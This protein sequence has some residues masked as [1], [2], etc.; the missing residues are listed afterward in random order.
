MSTPLPAS[1]V[2]IG[3]VLDEGAWSAFQKRVLLLAALAFAVDGLANQVLGLAI[4]ALIEHWGAARE[5]FA[6]VAAVGLIGVAVG[7]VLG[8]IAGDRFGRRSALIGSVLLFG[9]MTLASAFVRDIDDLLLVR[10]IDGIGLGAAIPNGAALI[11]E[12]T[13]LRHRSVAIAVGMVFIPVGGLLSGVLGAFVLPELGWRGLFLIAGLAPTL[14]AIVF[15]FVLPESPRVLVRRPARHRE[16]RALLARCGHQPAPDSTLVDEHAAGSRTPLGALFGPGML[17]NT[18]AL[19]VGFFFCL[20]ASYTMFS[21]VPTVLASR[22]FS[23]AMTSI[24]TTAFHLGGVIGGVTGGWLIARLG[25][26]VAVPG[27][28]AGCVLG[29][30]VLGLLPA[31]AEHGVAPTL[32]ALVVEG[33]F[34]AGLH[35][36]LY[37]LAAVIY[38]S[39][40]RATGIGA[41]SAVGRIG[42]VASSYTG[43]LTLKLGGSSS[44]FIVIAGAAAVSLAG[45]ALIRHHIPGRGSTP[46]APGDARRPASA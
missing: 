3:R 12:F 22:G 30:L 46:P 4:P 26:R 11:S 27:L 40:V 43:V 8:G 1:A 41:A 24:G 37:T 33:F 19:W 34:I 38:P 23:L 6:P 10:L 29:A 20:L 31:E 16:L 13:P 15:A 45:V 28:A 14:L 36:G 9:V 17:G 5:A 2:D 42:A 35:T 44:Y 39:F 21:W 7:T 32:A 18:L 25:S